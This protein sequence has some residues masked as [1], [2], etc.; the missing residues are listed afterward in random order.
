MVKY[1]VH[2]AIDIDDQSN[3]PSSLRRLIGCNVNVSN[4]IH[5]KGFASGINYAQVHNIAQK[6]KLLDELN[7]LLETDLIMNKFV[8]I[9][10][11]DFFATDS[12]TAILCDISTAL[13]DVEV[14]YWS[15][16]FNDDAYW[17]KFKQS[18]DNQLEIQVMN[19]VPASN[20]KHGEYE[21]IG[22]QSLVATGSKTVFSL[23]G[24]VVVEAEYNHAL[25]RD[26]Q[27]KMFDFIRFRHIIDISGDIPS[28]VIPSIPSIPGIP[29]NVG[30][31][32]RSTEA[33]EATEA[34]DAPGA[35][36]MQR[37]FLFNNLKI[38]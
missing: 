31:G 7:K 3:S 10:D 5:M 1:V 25:F 29:G 8:I 36:E 28:N 19:I 4:I 2:H 6:K 15:V 27:F 33:T 20:I 21:Q 24:G 35:V 11:G 14:E 34:M 23:G 17:M 18:W 9:F 38:L 12:Y 26:I 32:I 22:V 13:H 30:V 16:G 37:W